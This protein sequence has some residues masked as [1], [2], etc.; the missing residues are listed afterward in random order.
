MRCDIIA[1]GIIDGVSSLSRPIPLVVR[2]QGT[3][4]EAAKKLIEESGLDIL[5]IDDLDVA[6][7]TAV[8]FSEKKV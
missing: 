5:V 2:L 1:Q 4:V 3:Q 7:K 6:A 8:S